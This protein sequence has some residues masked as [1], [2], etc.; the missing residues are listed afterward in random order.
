M[1]VRWRVKLSQSF[2]HTERSSYT[3]RC[4]TWGPGC[5]TW[6]PIGRLERGES[7]ILAASP[8]SVGV[9][10]RLRGADDDNT[11]GP[12]TEWRRLLRAQVLQS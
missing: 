4:G 5:G 12:D 8:D 10:F 9:Q 11:G 1:R 6:V 2:G 7:K 3:L